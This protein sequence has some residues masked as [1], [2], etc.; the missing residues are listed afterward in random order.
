LH[1]QH[2]QD[3]IMSE[4]FLREAK[5]AAEIGHP[6]IVDVVDA[7]V[8]DKIGMYLAF[9]LLE[10]IDLAKALRTDRLTTHQILDVVEEVLDALEAAHRAGIIHRDV[11]PSNIFLVEGREDS[12]HVRVL[13]FGAA[14]HQHPNVE[15]SLTTF[16]RVIGTPAYLSP[17]QA[18]GHPVDIR[19]DIWSVGALL[20]RALAGRPPF[21]E[22]NPSLL[23][24]CIIRDSAP[25]LGQFRPDLPPALIALVDRALARESKKRWPSASAMREALQQLRSE[26]PSMSERPLSPPPADTTTQNP[27]DTPPPHVLAPFSP[28]LNI[29]ASDPSVN[30]VLERPPLPKKSERQKRKRILLASLLIMGI[31]FGTT[32]TMLWNQSSATPRDITSPSIA[33]PNPPEVAPSTSMTPAPPTASSSSTAISPVTSHVPATSVTVPTGMTSQPPPN[34]PPKTNP[35]GSQRPPVAPIR[36]YE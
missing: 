32:M 13:D 36:E 30:T 29:E 25:S 20:F 9:E 10:G 4:R 1:E 22:K 24:A 6:N 18:C 23:L 16:G 7:G 11:K 12:V 3:K 17:E 2:S 27:F 15:E 8:D 34:R 33:E 31:A 5:A 21:P 35:T 14:K 28:K 19:T 26:S